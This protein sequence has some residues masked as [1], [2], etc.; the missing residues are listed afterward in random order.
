MGRKAGKYKKKENNDS[1]KKTTYHDEDNDDMMNDEIDAFHKQRDIVPL[2]LDEDAGE[3][4]ADFEHPVLDFEDEKYDMDDNEDDNDDDIEDDSQLTGFAAKLLRQQKYLRA[5]TGGVEEEMDDD[6]EEEEEKERAVWGRAKSTFYNAENIDYEIQSSDE[7]LP[8]EEEE[9][10]LRLQKEKAKSLTE[11]DF[12]LE[13]VTDNEGDK[14]PTF[15]E[16]LVHG[17]PA[18]KPYA[19]KEGKEDNATAYEEVKKDINALTREEQMDVLNSSAPEL[20]G[21]LSELDD[22]LGQLENKVNPL[23]SKIRD[24]KNAI[25]GGM[26]YMEIKQ[27]LLLSYCQAITFYLLLK[28]E[29]QP[30]RD[31]PVISRLVEIKNLLDKMK[32]LDD[33]LPPELEDILDEN[34]SALRVEKLVQENVPANSVSCSEVHKP[35]AVP[36]ETIEKPGAHEGASLVEEDSFKE[37]KVTKSKSRHQDDQVGKQ[38]MEMLK[39]RAALEE[40]LKQKGIFSS[41]TNKHYRDKKRSLPVNGQLE[42]LEDFDDDAIELEKVNH[43]TDLRNGSLLHPLKLSKLVAPQANKI[44]VVSGDDDLPK[45]DDIG[46][47]RRKHELRVLA[48]AGIRTVDDVDDESGTLV[49]EGVPEVDLDGETESD[50]EFY[51][52]AELEHTAKLAAKAEMHTRSTKLTPLPETLVDGK[53]QISYQME[54]NRGLTRARKKLTKNPRKKYKLKH[55]KA[56]VRRKGQVRDIRKPTG[57]YGGE[58]SGINAAISRSIRFKS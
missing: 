33:N 53:R 55:Q 50:L 21:L 29:G 20:V 56:V 8:A 39:V 40:K 6:A 5:K 3:S 31:H 22:A 11:E 52:Q 45:R 54:K 24:V 57:T 12:G 9:E 19:S 32:E 47:R 2:D 1:K 16:I 13:D 51:K 23:L 36:V 28:S 34:E 30:V 10:V 44:K 25:K 4:D 14:E 37:Y 58:A 42:T 41:I 17:K 27:Q 46:E 7:E 43:R 38:S 18:F 35:A 48:G 49:N 26:H 15:E